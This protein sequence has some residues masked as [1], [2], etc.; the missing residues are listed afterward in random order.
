MKEQPADGKIVSTNRK[1][2]H[3]YIVLE[4]YEA[5]IALRGTEVKSLRAGGVS[6]MDSYAEVR[7]GELWLVGLHVSPFE[8]GNINNHDPKRDRK[9]LMHRQ[10]IHRLFGKVSQK[11]L[12]LV[13][14]SIYFKDNIV[15]VGLGLVQGKK[16]YDKREAIRKR[17]VDRE[18][19][20]K[21]R[22]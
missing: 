11:G 20:R 21:F 15:K 2:F 13:P 5:G 4:K 9:L 16:L 8:K 18:L 1:A 3:E 6:F 19:R 22:R 17:E 12:T 14:I 10:E 7:N